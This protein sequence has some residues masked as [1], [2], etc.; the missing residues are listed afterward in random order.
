M[1]KEE[2]FIIEVKKIMSDPNISKF[3]KSEINKLIKNNLINKILE[4]N[5]ENEALEILS[6]LSNS[7]S[8]LVIAILRS[9][10]E[11]IIDKNLGISDKDFYKIC[12]NLNKII[13]WPQSKA[14]LKIVTTP[15][16]IE[17]VNNYSEFIDELATMDRDEVMGLQ[18]YINYPLVNKNYTPKILVKYSKTK[19]KK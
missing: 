10:Q 13:P 3:A 8:G 2:K 19:E 1:T 6:T 15:E 16:I 9:K 14:Y 11:F 4:L 12:K 18:G 17:K 7:N 5:D